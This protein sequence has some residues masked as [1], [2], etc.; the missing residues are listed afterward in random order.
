MNIQGT[1]KK[2]F[3]VQSGTSK[4]GKPWQRQDFICE[5]THGEYPKAILLSTLE[6]KY[7]GHLAE[8]MEVK[9]SFDFTVREWTNPQGVVKYFNEPHIWRDGLQILTA[10]QQAPQQPP[11]Q[12]Y[13][14]GED[15]LPF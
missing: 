13:I 5:Y 6:D 14:P 3:P 11:Q 2:V 12:S 4:S 15:S 9:I 8:G 1:I 10:Q 7:A